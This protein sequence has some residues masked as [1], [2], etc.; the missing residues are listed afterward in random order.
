MFKFLTLENLTYFFLYAGG[1]F[2]VLRGLLLLIRAI[3]N[4]QIGGVFF[5]IGGFL[6]LICNFIS[7]KSP[8][9]NYLLVAIGVCFFIFYIDVMKEG[10]LE[11]SFRKKVSFSVL[12]ALLLLM[13][14]LLYLFRSEIHWPEFFSYIPTF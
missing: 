4:R 2:L 6:I 8:W 12:V 3:N 10:F 5:M 7:Y 9:Y 1:F 13:F 14:L 11:W